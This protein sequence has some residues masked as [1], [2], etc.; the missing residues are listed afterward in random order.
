MIG[1]GTLLAHY[2]T[3]RVRRRRLLWLGARR[4]DHRSRHGGFGVVDGLMGG[5]PGLLGI[6]FGVLLSGFGLSSVAS[7]LFAFQVP[8]PGDNP[9]KARPGGGFALMLATFVTWGTL[10][11]LVLSELVL[12][13]I[14]FA[15]GDTLYGWLAGW[16][17]LAVGLGLGGGLLCSYRRRSSRAGDPGA[18]GRIGRRRGVRRRNRGFPRG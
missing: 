17:A 11:V 3:V 7:A 6:S 5:A 1:T 15:T 13:I 18:R 9:F 10:G 8:A 12:A 14:G 4:P 2:Y 16:L